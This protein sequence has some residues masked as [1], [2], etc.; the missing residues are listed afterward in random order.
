MDHREP[1]TNSPRGVA[2]ITGAS[3]GIGRALALRLARDGWRVAA[4]A[5]RAEELARLAAEAR[6]MAGAIHAFPLDVT[7]P[8]AVT[9][10]VTDLEA[11]LGPLDLMV[12]NAGSYEPM[13]AESFSAATLRRL[14]DLNVMGVAHAIEAALPRLLAR[15]RGRIAIVAS[16]AG[17]AGLPYAAAYG[18]GKAALINM[19]EALRP[20]LLAKGIV[21]QVINPGFVRT[22]LTDRNDFPMPFLVTAEQAAAAIARGLDGDRFEIAFPWLF[23]RLLKLVRMLPYRFYFALTRRMVRQ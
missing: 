20:E 19:A 16:L 23:V 1:T 15:G 12:L 14:I 17:Y 5:R 22:P 11:Q 6:D 10:C 4:S 8:A 18:A 21:V 9:G 3:S 2:W 13:P 7:D